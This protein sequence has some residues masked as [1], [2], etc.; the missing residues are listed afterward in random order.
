MWKTGGTSIK[1]LDCSYELF[2]IVKDI[3]KSTPIKNN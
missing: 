1:G 3:K 2:N